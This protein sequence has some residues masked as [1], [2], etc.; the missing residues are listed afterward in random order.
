MRVL[1]FTEQLLREG[2]TIVA[3]CPELDVSSCGASEAEARANLRTALRLFLEEA[4]RMGTL[5]DILAE[6]GYDLSQEVLTSPT[7]SI[8]SQQLSLEGQLAQCLA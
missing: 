7:F 2:E 1:S 5:A 3:Y 8:T 4:A 6:A